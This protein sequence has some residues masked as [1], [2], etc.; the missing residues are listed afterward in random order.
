MDVDA[1][2]C[3]HAQRGGDNKLYISGAGATAFFTAASAVPFRIR[4]ALAATIALD[5]GEAADPHPV[6]VHI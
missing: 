1:M 3:D 4:L 5:L 2:L 6:S